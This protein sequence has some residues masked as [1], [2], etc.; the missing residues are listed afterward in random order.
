MNGSVEF[1]L[2]H[3]TMAT[4][5]LIFAQEDVEFGGKPG[6]TED[7]AYNNNVQ[8][9]SLNIR[10]GFLRK[11]YGLLTIQ[12][13]IS[14][15]VGAICMFQ[16]EV[17]TFIHT[18]TLLSFMMLAKCRANQ[19]HSQRFALTGVFLSTTDLPTSTQLVTYAA[20][21]IPHGEHIR[22]G[23]RE[24]GL[25]HQPCKTRFALSDVKEEK[26][27][28]S[29]FARTQN[30]ARG[31]PGKLF[32]EIPHSIYP[33]SI[34]VL[35]SLSPTAQYFS[36]LTF[37]STLI[38]TF[39]QAY[40]IG[41]VLT[42]YDQ[43]IVLQ[44]LVLTLSVVAG[45]SAFTFQTKRDFSF[46]GY[47]LFGGLMLLMVAAIM[48]L[49][50]GSSVFEL[51]ISLAGAFL[52]A[53]FIVYDTQMLMKTLSPEEYILATINLYLDIVNLFLYILRALEAVR[54]Q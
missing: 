11:V 35:F 21:R 41:V 2:S 53:I 26:A 50:L 27:L 4:I 54:R 16:P 3:T 52:F 13:T 43:V 10:M 46:L 24:R 23:Q 25:Y 47:G 39:V 19:Q 12:L 20:L 36:R 51:V 30:Y 44:A 33:E 15:I 34:K 28:K 7:F 37:A 38:Q 9:A 48:Q 22:H 14:A 32:L 42:F 31:G 29:K 40:A 6:I 8:Q 18:K 49:F 5:P 45:L 17:R 1:A